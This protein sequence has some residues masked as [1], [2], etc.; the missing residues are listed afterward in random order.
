MSTW[1]R[2]QEFPKLDLHWHID[3]CRC[4]DLYTCP[5]WVTRCS[6]W[7]LW[8]LLLISG[9][10]SWGSFL[11][12]VRVTIW[13]LGI[14]VIII[15]SPFAAKANLGLFYGRCKPV[16]F[17]S[18]FSALEIT[19]TWH[20]LAIS[21]RVPFHRTLWKVYKVEHLNIQKIKVSDMNTLVD[22]L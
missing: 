15:V 7:E 2:E 13:N 10:P 3:W 22:S 20:H 5:L 21:Y 6:I 8:Q 1:K 11:E 17:W 19:N 4:R 16:L 9:C 12:Q 18:K 14:P